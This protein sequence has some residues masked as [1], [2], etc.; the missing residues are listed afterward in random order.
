M[1]NESTPTVQAKK[2]LKTT[3]EATPAKSERTVTATP[4]KS[5]AVKPSRRE[6]MDATTTS[7]NV[8]QQCA[9]CQTASA[10]VKCTQCEEFL[11]GPCD[12]TVH[13]SR[14]MSKHVREKHEVVVPVINENTCDNCTK[15]FGKFMCH[16][17]DARLCKSCYR[18]IHIHTIF[19]SHV[20]RDASTKLPVAPH[21]VEEATKEVEGTSKKMY[22]DEETTPVA[23]SSPKVSVDQLISQQK[24]RTNYSS[25][26]DSDSDASVAK[27]TAQ[28]VVHANVATPKPVVVKKRTYS[29]SSSSSD[30]ALPV[31]KM[32]VSFSPPGRTATAQNDSDTSEDLPTVATPK[33]VVAKKAVTSEEDSSSSDS[34]SSDEETIIPSQSTPAKASGISNGSTHS[35][36][37]KIQAFAQTKN[38]PALHF[39]P[40]LNGYERLLAHDCAESLGLSHVS[41]GSG[42]ERHLVIDRR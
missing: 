3:K 15:M 13:A 26:E 11:C 25:S 18:R 7:D 31:P 40:S 21:L 24:S 9:E 23:V 5:S 34:S 10:T 36:V 19:R 39:S 22:F 17:C 32:K 41:V 8:P 38:A 37:G 30:D 1:S 16:E 35:V 6:A 14:V 12:S 4:S 2:K 20:K 42:L 27:P 33:K 28:P 29:S